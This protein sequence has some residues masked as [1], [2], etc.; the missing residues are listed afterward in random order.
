MTRQ[1]GCFAERRVR[2]AWLS[3]TVLTS[4]ALGAAAIAKPTTPPTTNKSK[5]GSN[6][7]FPKDPNFRPAQIGRVIFVLNDPKLVAV[8][9]PKLTIKHLTIEQVFRKFRRLSGQNMVNNWA[10]VKGCGTNLK[11]KL[12]F[13]L[14]AQSLRLDMAVA[15]KRFARRHRFVVTADQNVIF[16]TT[17]KQDDQ[18]LIFRSYYLPNLMAN[19]PRIIRGGR[20]L[21]HLTG[22]PKK[23]K[24]IPLGTNIVQLISSTVMP[25]VWLNHGGKATITEV[26]NRVIVIAPPCVQA[27]LKGPR[28]FNPNAAPR[29]LLY[30]F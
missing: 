15:L 11:K 16:L 27:I 23:S 12:S 21:Q 14:P 30:S 26:N 2:I 25:H 22:D 24:K 9:M 20:D 7:K 28:H 5:T 29:Y 8:S 10:A 17:Q 6:F 18:H 3:T 19:L 13:N 1:M 4:L